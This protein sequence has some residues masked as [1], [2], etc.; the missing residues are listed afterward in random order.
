[1]SFARLRIIGFQ[2]LGMLPLAGFAVVMTYVLEFSDADRLALAI[3]A[4]TAFLGGAFTGAVAMRLTPPFARFAV[5]LVPLAVFAFVVYRRLE[6]DGSGWLGITLAFPFLL[7]GIALGERLDLFD[8]IEAVRPWLARISEADLRT[9]KNAAIFPSQLDGALHLVRSNADMT[10]DEAY[11]L[12]T[13]TRW[14]GS[15]FELVHGR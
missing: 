5:L 14:N 11:L 15:A 10:P 4:F 6:I 3:L 8:R 7:S 12:V 1:M 13:R 9:S 2:L